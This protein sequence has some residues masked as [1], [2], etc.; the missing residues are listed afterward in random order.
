M[1]MSPPF[2]AVRDP[3]GEAHGRPGHGAR[4]GAAEAAAATVQEPGRAEFQHGA[5]GGLPSG[6]LR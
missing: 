3:H 6:K 2:S 5:F 1:N 4:R